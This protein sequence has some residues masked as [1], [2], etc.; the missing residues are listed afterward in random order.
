[1][2][3]AGT[4]VD[5]LVHDAR[6]HRRGQSLD[7]GGRGCALSQRSSLAWW[8]GGLRGQT[9]QSYPNGETRRDAPAIGSP[10]VS[11]SVADSAEKVEGPGTQGAKE[12][13][14]G[15]R[16]EN[17]PDVATKLSS[18]LAGL[19]SLAGPQRLANSLRQKF[20]NNSE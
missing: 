13:V 6:P 17:G 2:R 10:S 7:P 18:L 12:S 11:G 19:P 20:A 14:N 4:M 1:M 16:S 9:F 8:R 3:I 5:G 15:P